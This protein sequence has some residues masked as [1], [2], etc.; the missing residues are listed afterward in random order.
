MY[1]NSCQKYNTRNARV[2][3][4]YWIAVS[5]FAPHVC[6]VGQFTT[7]ALTALPEEVLTVIELNLLDPMIL[8]H[9]LIP[10]I[11]RFSIP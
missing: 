1:Q 3:S 10:S 8:K 2:L 5:V 9:A 6:C 11:D 7:F 4:I